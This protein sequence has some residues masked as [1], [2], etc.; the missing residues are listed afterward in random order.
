MSRREYLTNEI[1]STIKNANV[2][3]IPDE[4]YTDYPVFPE[5]TISF[6]NFLK[7]HTEENNLSIDICISDDNYKELEMHDAMVILS[8]IIVQ[9]PF[10]SI[11]INLISNYLY[12]LIRS[13]DEKSLNVKT[14]IIVEKKDKE[15]IN[16]HYEGPATE[17]N[18]IMKSIKKNMP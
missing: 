7:E 16:I 2:L 12:D 5:N 17:F 8:A 13:F 15:S 3:L 14:D 1:S 6:F 4:T 18:N 10:Y 11:I 9:E